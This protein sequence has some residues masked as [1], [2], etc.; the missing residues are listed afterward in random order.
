MAAILTPSNASNLNMTATA[1]SNFG[2]E[3][4]PFEPNLLN[5]TVYIIA[6]ALQL[7]TFAINYRVS[8]MFKYK[9]INKNDIY[10]VLIN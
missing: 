3:G 2:D 9:R 4:E 6:M 5:S 1:G 7:S 10:S 8:Y